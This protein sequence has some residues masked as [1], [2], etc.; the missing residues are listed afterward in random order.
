MPERLATL[1]AEK[2]LNDRLFLRGLI[3]EQMYRTVKEAIA[4]D[5]DKNRSTPY[6]PA[7]RTHNGGMNHGFTVG[8]AA[9]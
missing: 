9:T 1:Y 7:N 3:T 4:A 6:A 5:I 8:K 2:V